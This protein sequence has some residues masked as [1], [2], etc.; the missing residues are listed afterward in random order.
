[1]ERRRS[2]LIVGGGTAGWLTAAYLARSLR[3]AEQGHLEITLLESP[4]VGVIGV[5]EAT[6]P[7]IR[8]TLQFL[9]IDEG[10]FIRETTATFK[11]GIRFDDWAWAPEDGRRHQ[12]FHPFEAPFSTDGSS[13][14]PY[15]LL[16]D[17]RTRAPFAEAMT[18]QARVAAAQRAPKR[19]HEDDFAGPLN[20]AY[21]FDAIKLSQVL[22]ERAR[23]LGVRHLQ[24][25]VT[26]V[27][28]DGTG[29]IAGVSAGGHCRLEADLYIDCTG[30][31]AELIGQTLKSPFSSVQDVLFADRALACKIPYD[32]PDAPLQSFTVATAHEAGWL[33]DIGLSGARGVGCVYSSRHMSDDRARAVL[34][35]YVGKDLELSIRSMAFSAGYRPKAWVGNCV[36]VGLS[37]GFLEPLESTGVVLIEAAVAIIAELF[38]HSGP[39]NAPAQ[40]FNSLMSARYDNIVTFLKLHYCLSQRPEPFW[41]DNADPASIPVRLVELLEQWRHRPPSR[42]DFILDLETFAFFNYQYILYG[43]GFRTDLSPGRNAYPDAPAADRLFARIQ[44]YSDRALADL[45]GHRDLIAQIHQAGRDLSPG[46]A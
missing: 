2:I 11:Q 38:P 41:R 27:E 6:F 42:Y 15:W 28:V 16:Q 45:P 17:E 1:M 21:H 44:A 19:P 30:F 20:Y 29:D 13:L 32:R 26:G 9:G 25:H 46:T 39:V 4:E 43:M 33:W 40:R 7:T 3:I 18:I 37:A 31:R 23:E 22:A 35:A 24:G 10:R 36:A 5:G 8:N 34:Q 12:Y 14:A